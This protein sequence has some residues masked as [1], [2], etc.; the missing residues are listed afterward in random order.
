MLRASCYRPL[1]KLLETVPGLN[2]T[3]DEC[4]VGCH[5]ESLEVHW[6]KLTQDHESII[7]TCADAVIP[8][9]KH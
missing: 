5:I 8:D 6:G 2:E 1:V 3:V 4:V 7:S 9:E